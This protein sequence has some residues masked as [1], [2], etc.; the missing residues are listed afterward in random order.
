MAIATQNA[1]PSNLA[2]VVRCVRDIFE[3]SGDATPIMVGDHYLESF[4]VGAP[5]RILFVMEPRSEEGS[6]EPPI[7]QGRAA[8]WIHR[9]DVYVRASAEIDDVDRFDVAYQLT[10]KTISAIKRAGTGRVEFGKVSDDS[11]TRTGAF[12]AGFAFGFSYR[13][14]IEHNE[15]VMRVQS[16]ALDTSERRPV[17][18]PGVVDRGVTANIIMTVEES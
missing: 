4:G 17:A 12:G 5:P 1:A 16:A 6:I 3:A 9:C 15:S 18:P 10:D 11:P 7:Q 14:D 2:Q 8:S 13:R